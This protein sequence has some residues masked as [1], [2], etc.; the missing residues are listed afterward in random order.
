MEQ[1]A[2]A[3]FSSTKSANIFFSPVNVNMTLQWN[4]NFI[5]VTHKLQ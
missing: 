2:S 5:D 4:N 3:K 1:L